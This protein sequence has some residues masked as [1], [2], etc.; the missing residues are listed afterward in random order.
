MTAGRPSAVNGVKKYSTRPYDLDKQYVDMNEWIGLRQNYIHQVESLEKYERMCGAAQVLSEI[1]M[2]N[3]FSLL[4]A[5]RKITIRIADHYRMIV[6]QKETPL[7]LLEIH[8]YVISMATD[9]DC[10]DR[11]PFIDWTGLDLTFNPFVCGYRIDGSISTAMSDLNITSKKMSESNPAMIPTELVMDQYETSECRD[12]GAVIWGAFQED[13]RKRRAKAEEEEAIKQQLVQA[14]VRKAE[15]AMK[16]EA[17]EF[18]GPQA[19]E[20]RR[21]R[22][23]WVAW[24]KAFNLEI[25]IKNMASV[26]KHII[27]RNV[28]LDVMLE[29][30]L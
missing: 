6:L 7:N 24:K 11:Q 19:V 30:C 8:S 16:R 20:E 18:A 10:L 12:L 14:S 27:K 23:A 25:S 15:L 29:I 2:P 9:M 1:S 13:Q 4:I 21:R 26:R 28:I 5:I 22:R 17:F 3:F